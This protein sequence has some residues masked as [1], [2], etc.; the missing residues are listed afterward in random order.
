MKNLLGANM[1]GQ[2]MFQIVGTT[3]WR[4]TN[5]ILHILSLYFGANAERSVKLYCTTLSIYSLL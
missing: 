5:Q 2:K 4:S 1:A 3:L